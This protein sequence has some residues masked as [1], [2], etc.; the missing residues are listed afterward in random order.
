MTSLY[1]FSTP[2]PLLSPA[3]AARSR[4]LTVSG[5]ERP[6]PA[7]TARGAASRRAGGRP[8][9]TRLGWVFSGAHR[10]RQLIPG[11]RKARGRQ[12]FAAQSRAGPVRGVLRVRTETLG[13]VRHGP[14]HTGRC[15][16]RRVRCEFIPET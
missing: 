14:T 2:P 11:S 8:P 6:P 13:R 5:S 7:G 4:Q 16:P 3:R 10:A 9:A 15:M 12:V 1:K